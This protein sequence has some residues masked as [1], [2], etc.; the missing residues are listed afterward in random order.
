MSNL[1]IILIFW[2]TLYTTQLWMIHVW[3]KNQLSSSFFHVTISTLYEHR[4][5]IIVF[6]LHFQQ[7]QVFV[8][9]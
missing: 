5:D 9:R 1:S 8:I 4:I 7:L 3:K 6:L 2:R